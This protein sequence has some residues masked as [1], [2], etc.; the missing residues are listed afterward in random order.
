VF[1]SVGRFRLFLNHPPESVALTETIHLSGFV[2][3]F[4]IE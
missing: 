3:P 2:P 1:R 4:K